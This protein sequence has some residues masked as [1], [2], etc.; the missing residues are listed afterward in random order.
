MT[1]LPQVLVN[2]PG[3]DKARADSAPPPRRGR[4]RAE[5][6]ALA[7]TGR[8]LLRPSGTEPLV[9]GHGRGGVRRTP[10]TRRRR[11]AGHRRQGP[12]RPLS[13]RP[14]VTSAGVGSA[15][16]P[17]GGPMDIELVDNDDDVALKAWHDIYLA[18]DT[19]RAPVRHA[20][21]VRGD[22]RDGARRPRDLGAAELRRARW[23]GCRWRPR[24][25]SSR[26]ATTWRTRCSSCTSSPSTVAG[27][28]PREMFDRLLADLAPRGAPCSSRRSTS[29]STSAPTAPGEPGVEFLRAQGF[30]PA[31][32]ATCMRNLALPVDEAVL[33]GLA[34]E[35]RTAP[36]GLPTGGVRRPLPR[37]ARGVVR[38]R[39][40][41]SSS[42]RR[43]WAR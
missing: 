18:A 25:R 33:A 10:R 21:A 11:P 22:A 34:E 1:R 28:T 35:A 16:S 3:V 5:E 7:G 37:R 4:R 31:H 36:P 42:T 39:C 17:T 14:P 43:R 30:S 15:P 29:P 2:V 38:E 12:A 19:H 20:V 8:V 6:A 26:C 27:A 32:W 40:R 13:P 24:E 23:T 41:R 9:Q